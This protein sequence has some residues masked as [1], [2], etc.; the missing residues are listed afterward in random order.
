MPVEL[1]QLQ[2]IKPVLFTC[3]V[4]LVPQHLA[5]QYW[6]TFSHFFSVKG[7]SVEFS[8][9]SAQICQLIFP[10]Q[11]INLNLCREQFTKMTQD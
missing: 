11:N 9:S 1:N 2:L 10:L 3:A 4:T 5:Y 8:L 6:R 7:S